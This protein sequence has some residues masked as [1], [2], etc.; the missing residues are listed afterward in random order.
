MS[1]PRSRAAIVVPVGLASLASPAVALAGNGLPTS[2]L[3]DAAAVA[4]AFA[5]PALAAGAY[6]LVRSLCSRIGLRGALAFGAA[7]IAAGFG[8]AVLEARPDLLMRLT[9]L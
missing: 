4:L 1:R 9:G 6:L 8:W 5:A 3:G 2:F 7:G